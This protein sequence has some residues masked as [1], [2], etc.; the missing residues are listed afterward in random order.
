[1][2]CLLLV[3]IIT[4]G[5]ATWQRPHIVFILAD[6]LG[7][8]DVGFHGSKQIP[9]PNIDTLAYDGIILNNYYVQPICTPTRSAL[10]TGRHPIHTGMQQGVIVGAQPYGLGL[11]ETILPQYLKTLGYK[12]HIVGKWH[13]G[14]FAKEY[15][16]TYRG[17]DSHLG[18]YQGMEGYWD[19][20][21]QAFAGQKDSWGLDFR[22]DGRLVKTAFG[23]YSTELF[24]TEAERIIA[25][26]DVSKPLF[27]YL[28]HQAV[29]SANP[30]DPLEAPW[31]Y[32]KQFGHI[33]HKGRRTFAAMMSALDDSIGNIT[34]AL[35]IRGMLNNSVI[36]F[37]SDN[38]GPAHGFDMNYANN[39][40]L[41]GVKATLWEGGMRAAGFLW[42]PLLK[43]TNYVSNHLVQVID[44][45][46]TLL[47]I[48]GYNMSQ[49]PSS[50]DGFDIWR[51]LSEQGP[52]ARS[53]ILH[54]IE[55]RAKPN[56]AL[57]MLD[58][59]L[60]TGVGDYSTWD[61]WYPPEGNSSEEPPS[62]L[63]RSGLRRLLRSLGREAPHGQPVVVRCGSKPAN[64][65]CDLAKAPCLFNIT[66][67]PCEFHNVADHF[68]VIVRQLLARL[69]EYNKTA[70]PIH[71]VPNDPKGLPRYHNGV[72][73]PWVKLGA[74]ED[75]AKS[76][77]LNEISTKN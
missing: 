41:R 49:L 18:Y 68:P 51:M 50:V 48:A 60:M 35:D 15:T 24:T 1:M 52:P 20:T 2:V 22:R 29:H 72:W 61:G 65:T 12:T 70:V 37:S 33:K 6:D 39:W 23:Q 74:A 36:V 56:A 76:P 4:V 63:F 26:H 27:L 8:N 75:K 21:Y 40:P 38:G 54:N 25:E 53:E 46:P 10:L 43:R 28:P 62:E 31:K 13:L 16:P 77:A 67:D 45:L 73:E 11:N 14:M 47:S 58:M 9:T 30:S 34:K 3:V 71:N 64:A 69:A 19:H 32:L 57:R 66:A 17:F 44:W 59:K 55:P 5:G 42:S 7:W